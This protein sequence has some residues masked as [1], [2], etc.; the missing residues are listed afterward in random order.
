MQIIIYAAI[1]VM[2][3]FYTAMIGIAIGS[4]MECDGLK[5]LTVQFCKNYGGPVVMLNSAFNVVSDFFILI[6][7]YPLLM[8]LH[9]TLGRKIGLL[10]VF[11]AGLA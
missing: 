7:P 10:A 3:A 1:A 6:L 2:T 9:L 4:L 11:S 8:K 5:A